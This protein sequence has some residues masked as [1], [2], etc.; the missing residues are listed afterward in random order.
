MNAPDLGLRLRDA[1]LRPTV[2]RQTVL[3]LMLKSEGQ[4]RCCEDLYRIAMAA[5]RSLNVSSI[6]HALS[7]L[8]RAGLLVRAT[9][10]DDRR[11][12]Y[13]LPV[14]EPQAHPPGVAVVREG[15][16]H[17]A[18]DDPRAV[19]WL[20]Q[21]LGQLGIATDEHSRVVVGVERPSA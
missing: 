5:R 19:Q 20:Q 10:P 2:G 8:E 12:Y 11:Q 13:R 18:V 21:W 9:V 17:E 7:D 16:R 14:V 1:G 4:P 3:G 6:A 15:G